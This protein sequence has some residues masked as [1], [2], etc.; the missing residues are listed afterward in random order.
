MHQNAAR[1]GVAAA[2][3]VVLASLGAPAAAAGISLTVAKAAATADN[4]MPV[5]VGYDLGIFQEARARLENRRF[6]Q[7]QQ[8]VVMAFLRSQVD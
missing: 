8:D 6:Q 2:F 3:A 4:M 7:R 1:G 5:N